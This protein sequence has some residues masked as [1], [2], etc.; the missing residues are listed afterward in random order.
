MGHT[1]PHLVQCGEGRCHQPKPTGVSTRCPAGRRSLAQ[2]HEHK[3]QILLPPPTPTSPQ[4]PR[5]PRAWESSCAKERVALW[6]WGGGWSGQGRTEPNNSKQRTQAKPPA[7][8]PQAAAAPGY[9]DLWHHDP[10]LRVL[11]QHARDQVLQVLGYVGPG[12]GRHVRGGRQTRGATKGS[13]KEVHPESRATLTGLEI[14][15]PDS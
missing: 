6:M 2:S 15:G 11:V 3:P 1:E 14:P 13:G 7:H 4:Q 10:R 12:G 8:G 9:L 5:G